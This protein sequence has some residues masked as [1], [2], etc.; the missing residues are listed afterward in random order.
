M[1]AQ[2]PTALDKLATLLSRLP[3]VGA[4]TGMRWGFHIL[5]GP[6]AYAEDLIQALRDVLDHVHFCRECHHLS[7]LELCPVCADPGRETRVLCV[8]EGVADVL[9]LERSRAF[10]GR[11]HV[12]H[13]ALA[14]LKGI[15][16]GQLRLDT[17]EARIARDGVEEVIVATSAD[18]EGEAT[19]LYLARRLAPTGV[20][21]SRIATGV[22]MGGELEYLDDHTL[23][24][25]LEGRVRLDGGR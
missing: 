21:V 3:G 24:R 25:A 17:L 8:V 9:A 16:P 12:M 1:P 15:G 20:R 18:V 5:G 19:A 23:S 13:G 4:R 7:E 11:Y 22:P 2:L 14:P 6:R 10:R